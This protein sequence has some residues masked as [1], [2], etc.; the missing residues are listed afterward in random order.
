LA[1]KFIL[2]NLKHRVRAE[3]TT[4]ELT[5]FAE[6]LQQDGTTKNPDPLV[7]FLSSPKFE[8]HFD[9]T[10]GELTLS[11]PWITYRLKLLPEKDPATVEQ[12][13][14]FSDGY[15]LLNSILSPGSLP[16][17][18][19][20]MVND[21]LAKHQSMASQVEMTFF[22]PGKGTNRQQITVRST[23]N[24]VP[25]LTSTDLELVAKS[26]EY[27]NSFKLVNFEQYR[28]IEQQ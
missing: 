12:Y 15:K 17:F 13:H 1:S 2:L 28:K 20:L 27:L 18:G 7:K 10:P 19:R 5:A 21:A 6:R 14:E 8:E 22:P 26:R 23:H 24:V 9:K 16:P 4:R 11:S 25:L 3:L